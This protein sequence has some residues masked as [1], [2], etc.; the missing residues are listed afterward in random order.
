VRRVFVADEKNSQLFMIQ[1][2]NN[3]SGGNV[4]PEMSVDEFVVGT[5]ERLQAVGQAAADA[6][7]PLLEQFTNAI[8]KPTELALEFGLNVGGEAGVPFVTK[9]SIGANFKV[10]LKW[11]GSSLK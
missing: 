3:V 9:G 2:A 10:T 5:R 7:G 4:T 8:V 1:I 6:A 11:S